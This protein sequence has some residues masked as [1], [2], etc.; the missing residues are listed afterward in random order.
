MSDEARGNWLC[1]SALDRERLVDMH[2]RVAVARRVQGVCVGCVSL[3]ASAFL[4][5]WLLGLVALGVGVLLGL[6]RAYQVTRRP[7]VVSVASLATLEL[8]LA[9]AAGG[10]GGVHSPMLSWL[11]I[12]IVMLASRFP[13]RIV[14]VGVVV[15]TACTLTAGAVA[16]RLPPAREAPWGLAVACWVALLLS[17]VAATGA[18][19][20]AELK[21][22]GDAVTDPLTGLGN[23]LA[24]INRFEQAA[25]QATVMN[26]WTSVVMCDLDNFKEINDT[27]GHGDG[28]GVLR[29]AAA[30]MQRELR[31]FDSVYRIGGDEFVVLLPGLELEDAVQLANRLRRSVSAGS[32]GAFGI[33][34]SAGVAAARGGAVVPDTL[35]RDADQALYAAKRAGR[36]QVFAAAMRPALSPKSDSDSD[37]DSAGSGRGDGRT[38][39]Q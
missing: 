15:A 16:N 27:R 28:D 38:V 3:A 20:S 30:A 12:P 19:L 4:G 24:M 31:A 8:I 21:S 5:W 33:T 9:V 36:N 10:T 22:R 14:A 29:T 39:R 7:E 25:A 23:R 37:S 26:A 35:L 2:A 11:A 32:V 6:E 18:L 1:P 13:W 34:V 17:L